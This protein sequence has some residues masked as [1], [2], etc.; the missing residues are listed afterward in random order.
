MKP[1][2]PV[3]AVKRYRAAVCG[4]CDSELQWVKRRKDGNWHCPKC[5]K[6]AK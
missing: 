1:A 2:K 6:G 3:V 4:R 5:D